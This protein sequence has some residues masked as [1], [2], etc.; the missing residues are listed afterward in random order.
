MILP[1]IPRV[2]GVCSSPF[3]VCSTHMELHPSLGPLSN[4][5]FVTSV[6]DLG[7]HRICKEETYWNSGHF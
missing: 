6:G 4:Y 5:S 7:Q 2:R 1:K 3:S